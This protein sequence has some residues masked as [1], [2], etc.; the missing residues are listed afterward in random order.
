[1]K[2]Y[3]PIRMVRL[4]TCHEIWALKIARRFPFFAIFPIGSLSIW[5]ISLAIVP[6]VGATIAIVNNNLIGIVI[7]GGICL[8]FL[9][10][11]MPL[12]FHWYFVAISLM[13]GN[14]QLAR[15]M[16]ARLKK[17]VAGS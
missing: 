12:F 13:F 1:M 16:D 11:S 14:E 15:N 8:S 4:F 5:F 10:M 6:S 9:L 2:R 17:R 3:L 7:F